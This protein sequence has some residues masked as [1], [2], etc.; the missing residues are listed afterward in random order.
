MAVMAINIAAVVTA[1]TTMFLL[2][3]QNRKADRGEGLCEG[4]E[5]FRYTL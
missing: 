3:R 1:L 5:G 2:R 4:R